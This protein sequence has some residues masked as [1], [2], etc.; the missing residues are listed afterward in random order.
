MSQHS[1]LDLDFRQ[2]KHRSFEQSYLFSFM[3]SLKVA[4]LKCSFSINSFKIFYSICLQTI[5]QS[6]TEILSR[7]L[8][9]CAI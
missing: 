1:C 3:I 2:A 8:V 4:A 9:E 5:S 6:L 7:H